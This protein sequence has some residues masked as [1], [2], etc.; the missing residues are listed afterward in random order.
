MWAKVEGTVVPA[1]THSRGSVSIHRKT[2][3]NPMEPSLL[4]VTTSGPPQP[5]VCPHHLTLVVIACALG[6]QTDCTG[7][8]E[9]GAWRV[10]LAWPRVIRVRG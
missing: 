6:P 1:D 4:G 8:R 10:R 2:K 5:P 7:P 3:S 9:F